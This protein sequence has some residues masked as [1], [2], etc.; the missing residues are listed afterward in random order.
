MPLL[1]ISVLGHFGRHGKTLANGKKE[2]RPIKNHKWV[3]RLGGVVV[4][5]F[6][7]KLAGVV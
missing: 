3:Y 5:L 1:L 4:M 7:L 2:D 6:T